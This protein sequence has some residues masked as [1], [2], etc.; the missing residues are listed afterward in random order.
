MNILPSSKV[1]HQVLL[2]RDMPQVARMAD[3]VRQ[4]QPARGLVDDDIIGARDMAT[5]VISFDN[6]P[7]KDDV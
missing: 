1:V 7:D 4:C 3:F 2:L 5:Y 6:V